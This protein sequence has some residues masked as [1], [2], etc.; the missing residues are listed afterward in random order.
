[1]V[2]AL[3][4]L[5]ASLGVLLAGPASADNT[6]C[7]GTIIGGTFDNV[8]V[9]SGATCFLIDTTVEGS[10]KAENASN[11]LAIVGGSVGGDVQ[12]DGASRVFLGRGTQV[13]GNVSIEGATLVGIGRGTGITIG[14][15]LQVEENEQVI[16]T[17]NRV[18]GNLQAE[19]NGSVG[20]SGNTIEENLQCEDNGSVVGGN[21]AVEGNKKGQCENL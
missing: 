15:N 11:L 18:G 6:I 5:V 12:T 4:A 16:I 10:V 7:T 8:I 19:E 14:G 3:G 13:T 1:M 17:D 20:I 9:P 2:I 21:N